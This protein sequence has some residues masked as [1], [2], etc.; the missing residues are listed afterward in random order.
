MIIRN[1]ILN[2]IDAI[3]RVVSEA[4]GQADE[5][6]LIQVLEKAGDAVIS[7]VAEADGDIVGHVLLSK[8]QAPFQALALAPVSVTPGRQGSGVGSALVREALR[9]AREDGW[10]AVFVLGDPG[11]YGR[12]GFSVERAAGFRSP[13]AGAHFAM[14]ALT[15]ERLATS[16]DLSHAPAFAALG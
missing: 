5:A 7:L 11:Y 6:G 15:T 12:F 1:E 3:H 14:L 10:D 4:F 9:R 2:D 13:Y 8:M 16:G